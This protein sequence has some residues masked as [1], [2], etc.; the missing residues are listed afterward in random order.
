MRADGFVKRE[1]EFMAQFEN[2]ALNGCFGVYMLLSSILSLPLSLGMVLEK[3]CFTYFFS[4]N[5][6]VSP[7]LYKLKIST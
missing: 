3:M 2:L 4:S 6:S 7:I 5:S 1:S